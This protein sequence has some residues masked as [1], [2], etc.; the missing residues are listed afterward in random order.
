M[1]G[2]VDLFHAP[3]RFGSFAEL[4]SAL[5]NL[6]GDPLEPEGGR[7]VIYRGNPAARLMIVGE[8]PGAEEDRLGQPFVG[9]SGKLLDAILQSVG[10]DPAVDVFVTNSAFRRPRD[11]RKPTTEEIEWYR[12]WLTEIIR[13]ID[14]KVILLTGAVALQSVL[15]ERRGITK[16]RGEWFDLD[17]RKVMPIFHPAYLLRNPSS[18]EGSPKRLMWGDVQE[19]RRVLD[20][21]D[22][23]SA[24][25]RPPLEPQSDR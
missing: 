11:N 21:L 16:V 25:L 7:I 5:L 22:I 20:A 1:S 3:L 19:V 23:R 13:L 2:Q 8:A 6:T 17:G 4:E 10:F 12:P 9:K 18:A 14:P 15:D 24:S